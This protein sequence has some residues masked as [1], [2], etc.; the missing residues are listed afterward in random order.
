[1]SGK[2]QAVLLAALSLCLIVEAAVA[3]KKSLLS[4]AP[5]KYSRMANPLQEDASG[6][7]TGRR[8]YA[9]KC[10]KCHETDRHGERRAPALDSAEV[11]NAAPGA[12]YWVLEKG[13]GDMP[14]FAKYPA[15]YRWQ[16]VTFL[17]GR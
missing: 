13:G 14:S 6:R 2:L 16:L 4:Q 8:I 7:E 10:A 1:M 5:Q 17:K 3:E 12:L 15:Q 9:T 11:R